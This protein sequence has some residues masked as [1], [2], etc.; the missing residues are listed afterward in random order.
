MCTKILQQLPPMSSFFLL[1]LGFRA[2]VLGNHTKKTPNY[3]NNFDD[4][5]GRLGFL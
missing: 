1:T 3:I 4:D 5:L 2:Y